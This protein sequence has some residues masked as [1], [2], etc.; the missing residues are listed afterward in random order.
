MNQTLRIRS[1][2]GRTNLGRRSLVL[3]AGAALASSVLVGCGNDQ[4]S[5]DATTSAGTSSEL[6]VSVQGISE[7]RCA[8]N[9]AAGELTFLSPFDY[10]A[11]AGIIDVVTAEKQGYFDEM[12]LSVK[13]VPSD[14]GQIP[15]LLASGVAQ[16]ASLGS[17][18]EVAVANAAEAD[19][20]AL[21]QYGHTTVEQL[22]VRADS[23]V[24]ELSGVSNLNVG[25]K[26]GGLPY[27][28]QAMLAGA[29]VDVSS[30][31]TVGVGYALT[32]FL[33]NSTQAEGVYKSNEPRRL[34]AENVDYI[35][36]DPADY[37]VAGSFGVLVGAGQFAADNPT[38][39]EDFV[40]ASL[41]GYEYAVSNPD[42][43]IAS[44]LELADSNFFFSTESEMFRWQVERGLIE[45][46]TPEG[47]PVGSFDLDAAKQEIEQ[48][49]RTLPSLTLPDPETF[50]QQQLVDSVYQGGQNVIWPVG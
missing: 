36:F 22:V 2:Q 38:V 23:G 15:S 1:R 50:I 8:L 37:Q 25:V 24:T 34:D 48:T 17:L 46:S 39:T 32:E 30:L 3:L 11:S 35:A 9:R 19:L 33:G 44:A 47:Q 43:A 18:S 40:R 45:A 27:G 29:G 21:A 14:T 4:S 7:A 20:V 12:C 28:V 6:T 49:R 16:F 41:H 26:G 31:R 42:A 5:S 10:A 13:I